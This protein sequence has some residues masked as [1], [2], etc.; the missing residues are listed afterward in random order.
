MTAPV[1]PTAIA[2]QTP[3]G[4]LLKNG[5]KS[6]IVFTSLPTASF[7]EKVE[8]GVKPGKIDGGA[9]INITT[10]RNTAVHTK[11]PRALIEEGDITVQCLFDPALR[12]QIRNTLLN[13]AHDTITTINSDGST[14]AAYGYLMSAEFSN[15]ENG[16]PP[17]VTL[18]IVITNIDA[19]GNESPPART[20][21]TGT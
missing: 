11:A 4:L 20:E 21:T 19:N 3:A 2:A 7:W 18:N 12:T 15:F 5:F 1:A 9:P 6:L 14:E 10:M 16:K 17:E 13:R 8:G